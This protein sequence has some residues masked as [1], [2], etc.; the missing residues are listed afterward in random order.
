MFIFGLLCRTRFPALAV[1]AALLA[2]AALTLAPT[3]AA[4]PPDTSLEL[5]LVGDSDN[6]VPPGSTI[7]IDADIVYPLPLQ[8]ISAD[9]VVRISGEYEWEGAAGRRR[10]V[11]DDLQFSGNYLT[12]SDL[13]VDSGFGRPLLSGN[14]MVALSQTAA[15]GPRRIHVYDLEAGRHLHLIMP[16]AGADANTFGDGLAVWEDKVNGQAFI[17]VGAPHTLISGNQQDCKEGDDMCWVGALY[18]YKLTY[19]DGMLSGPH[20]VQP[21]AAASDGKGGIV[22]TGMKDEREGA[23]FGNDAAISGDG[24]TLVVG[25]PKANGIGSVWVFPRPSGGDWSSGLTVSDGVILSPLRFEDDLPSLSDGDDSNSLYAEGP[26]P[27]YLAGSDTN[28]AQSYKDAEFGYSVAVSYDGATIAVGAPNKRLEA[29]DG[30]QRGGRVGAIQEIISEF[31]VGKIFR[32]GSSNHIGLADDAANR[33]GVAYVY[34]RSGSAWTSNVFPKTELAPHNVLDN[35][36]RN[37]NPYVDENSVGVPFDEERFSTDIAIS[38]DGRIV[39][40]AAPQSHLYDGAHRFARYKEDDGVRSLFVGP[41][42]PGRVYIWKSTEASWGDNYYSRQRWQSS[43]AIHGTR[44][45]LNID[46]SPTAILTPAEADGKPGGRFGTSVSFDTASGPNPVS[47]RLLVGHSEVHDPDDRGGSPLQ[48]QAW[49]FDVRAVSTVSEGTTVTTAHSR[50]VK[51]ES[52]EPVN[53]GF[54]GEGSFE[55]GGGRLVIGQPE[56]FTGLTGTGTGRVWVFSADLELVEFGG[57]GISS[58]GKS[59]RCPIDLDPAGDGN[60]GRIDIPLEADGATLTITASAEIDG[61]TFT[62]T[63]KVTVGEVDEVTDIDFQVDST[64]DGDSLPTTL[65]KS[66][67][68]SSTTLVLSILNE[69]G[70]GSAAGSVSSVLFASSAG[71]LSA[72]L[73]DAFCNGGQLCQIDEQRLHALN[74]HAIKLK[75]EHPGT[76]GATQ[77]HATVVTAD[78]EDYRE[79]IALKFAG[80]A[81]TLTIGE[82]T[83]ALGNRATIEAG[84]N[85]E[86]DGEGDGD[87]NTDTLTL[88]VSAVDDAGNSVSV[89]NSAARATIT[90]PD[91]R[92]VSPSVIST[93]WTSDNDDDTDGVQFAKNR[94]GA[95]TVTLIV[96][97]EAAITAGAYELTLRTAGITAVQSFA[98]A[99]PP[100][101]VVL[102]EPQ[103]SLQI[104]SRVTFAATVTDAN[105]EPVADGTEV[106]FSGSSVANE[107]ALLTLITPSPTTT[108]SGQASATWLVL[109]RGSAFISASAGDFNDVDLIELGVLPAV[110]PAEALSSTEADGF[111]TYL[112][113]RPLRASEL[114]AGLDSI[115]AVLLWRDGGWVRYGLSPDRRLIPGSID[116]EVNLGN[117]VWLV[118]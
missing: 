40:A 97:S 91:G 68:A 65:T 3:R 55:L 23:R 2:A 74:S 69:N 51:I 93:N 101:L 99:G 59:G 53:R 77:V 44:H 41:A 47:S 25:A 9:A 96:N 39:A 78:G 73:G 89:P 36:I 27:P 114:L 18:I 62:D 43:R 82:P 94:A 66:G 76:A 31:R 116:F 75:V 19:S 50:A 115:N 57:C 37:T 60:R 111:A 81:K 29:I 95:T 71:K 108:K 49:V 12:G 8:Q 26:N 110:I 72:E 16:P 7:E 100:N 28:L 103:G 38:A 10:L 87:D 67:P 84:E 32:H 80:D 107:G 17:F 48:G 64:E 102:G 46:Q 86:N 106:V 14:T 33:P 52:P 104:G 54:F 117:I 118:D 35:P 70:K 63:L 24:L 56:F 45:R 88:V 5:T 58:D 20:T 21:A 90:G 6:T 105:G 34:E 98:V 112:S 1:L 42:S 79:S 22:P 15:D 4:P 61:E 13:A 113:E 11:I 92:T 83:S 109:D 30:D 85:A